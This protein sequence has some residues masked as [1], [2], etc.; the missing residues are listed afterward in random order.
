MACSTKVLSTATCRCLR[1]RII[2]VA[3]GLEADYDYDRD[4]LSMLEGWHCPKLGEL[5]FRA[6]MIDE[7][8]TPDSQHMVLPLTVA[9]IFLIVV[10][11]RLVFGDWGTA[12]NVGC[13]LVALAT[14]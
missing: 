6:L 4:I 5:H 9:V 14:L 7:G 12:W 2:A 13:F 1:S 10:S 11:A 8:R 3:S